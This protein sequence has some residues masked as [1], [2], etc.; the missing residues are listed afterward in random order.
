MAGRVTTDSSAALEALL[1][2]A[3]VT[4]VSVNVR[5]VDVERKG[6]NSLHD[7]F[8]FA[9]EDG[10]VRAL[11]RI[12]QRGG[13]ALDESAPYS[14]GTLSTGWE[15]FIVRPPAAPNGQLVQLTRVGATSRTLAELQQEGWLSKPMVELLTHAVAAR[16]NM[17]IVSERDDDADTLMRAFASL[18]DAPPLWVV[19]D[20]AIAPKGHPAI[21]LDGKAPGA[22]LDACGELAAERVMLPKLRL[23]AWH[24]LLRVVRRGRE[25]MVARLRGATVGAALDRTAAGLAAYLGE[26]HHPNRTVTTSVATFRAWLSASFLLAV[27]VGR[28]R[29]GAPRII[30]LCELGA[31]EI[32]DLFEFEPEPLPT[33]TFAKV[34]EGKGLNRVLLPRGHTER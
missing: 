16:C 29:D 13:V 4:R 32:L 2:D 21:V 12:C 34:G 30:R 7:G 6:H 8:D 25:G 15:L 18:G 27:E 24:T 26:Q 28:I 3:D 20:A 17:L 1:T 5:R 11:A 23:D 10:L 19:N 9:T 31:D 33:G 22:T 14:R